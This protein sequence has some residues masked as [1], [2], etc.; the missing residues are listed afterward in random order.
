MCSLAM[1]VWQIRMEQPYAESGE[2]DSDNNGYHLLIGSLGK[3]FV[4]IDNLIKPTQQFNMVSSFIYIL[5]KKKKIESQ[6]G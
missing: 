4:C 5:Q 6:W 2:V 1:S 3:V